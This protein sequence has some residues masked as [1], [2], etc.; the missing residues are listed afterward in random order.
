MYTTTLTDINDVFGQAQDGSVAAIIQILND[1]LA[2]N[3]IRT[4]AV[5]VDNVLQL[6]CEAPTNEQ[7][8]KSVV[9]ENIRNI[10]ENI[11]PRRIRRVK[12]NSR[13][14]QEQQLLWLEEISRDPDNHLLWAETIILKQP[15]WFKR[16]LRDLR[17]PKLRTDMPEG[18]SKSDLRQRKSFLGNIIGGLSVALLLIGITA[19]AYK[20]LATAPSVADSSEQTASAH[21]PLPES[22]DSFARA[23]RIAE[24]AAKDGSTAETSSDWLALAA[25]WQQA[26]D[27]MAEVPVADERYQIAQDRVSAY[28]SNSESLL[29]KA[30]QVD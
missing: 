7:L 28:R 12:I 22:Y 18:A 21:L 8:E 9:V 27:L 25:R 11:A 5:F 29:Q 1:R 26:S 14:V 15:H 23:V 2:N 30:R 20:R 3:G 17:R 13:L 19:W 4:R 6:L 24:Q 10:L 16:T